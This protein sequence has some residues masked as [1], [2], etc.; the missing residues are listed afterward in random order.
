MKR[1]P[2][3]LAVVSVLVLVGGAGYFGTRSVQGA[4]TSAAQAPT[5]VDVTRGEVQQTV[6]APGRFVAAHQVTLEAGVSGQ[7][8]EVP[9]RAGDPV[10]TG[11]LLVQIDPGPLAEAVAAAEADL[12]IARAQRAQLQAGPAAAEL[13]AAELARARPG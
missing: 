13:A 8:V 3:L 9:V 6:T 10:Q 12:E 4:S 2:V 1:W 5:T 11:D 7:I